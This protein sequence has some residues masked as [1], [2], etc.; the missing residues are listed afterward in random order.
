[1]NTS[2][3]KTRQKEGRE[4]WKSKS[5]TLENQLR[6]LPPLPNKL[7]EK[8]VLVLPGRI[9][10]VSL[11]RAYDPEVSDEGNDELIGPEAEGHELD[12]E[13][14]CRARPGLINIQ[15]NWPGRQQMA[16]PG[17]L[18]GNKEYSINPV[19][20]HELVHQGVQSSLGHLNK[21]KHMIQ[22]RIINN[23]RV[24]YCSCQRWKKQGTRVTAFPH[25]KNLFCQWERK[26]M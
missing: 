10:V 9:P 26:P 13:L 8:I 23:L 11:N 17:K 1:M 16:A 22:G 5:E 19:Q 25:T 7:E 2:L 12:T 3:V 4:K 24:W 14:L 20:T 18:C 6:Q 21:R 15:H